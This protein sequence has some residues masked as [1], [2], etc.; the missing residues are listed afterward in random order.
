M[1]MVSA[2]LVFGSIMHKSTV[3]LSISLISCTYVQSV[4]LKS[5]S[6]VVK[7][8]EDHVIRK[9]IC[10]DANNYLSIY[11]FREYFTE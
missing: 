10:K 5:N 7:Q 1:D 3:S 8:Q 4:V 11:N 9:I 6:I 2:A